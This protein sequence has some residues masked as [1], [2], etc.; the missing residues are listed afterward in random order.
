MKHSRKLDQMLDTRRAEDIAKIA[1]LSI[2]AEFQN[3]EREGDGVELAQSMIESGLRLAD[4]FHRKFEKARDQGSWVGSVPKA[5]S[6]WMLVQTDIEGENLFYFIGTLADVSAKIKK[7][8]EN[9]P[10]MA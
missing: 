4:K 1:D 10:Y 9:R 3:A 2:L 7:I 5:P 6:L 8:A